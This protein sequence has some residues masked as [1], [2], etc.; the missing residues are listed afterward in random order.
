MKSHRRPRARSVLRAGIAVGTAA[1]ATTAVPAAAA[2]DSTEDYPIPSRI[3][4]TPCT[5]EQLL[6][7]ARDYDPVYYERY[8]IDTHTKQPTFS[9]RQ[10][11]RFTGFS[12][13]TTPDAE[14]TRTTCTATAWTRCGWPGPTT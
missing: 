9:R 6:A 12:P 1:I 10:R 11:T 14:P 3:L 13:W 4:H 5:A 7:A 2:A 8:M